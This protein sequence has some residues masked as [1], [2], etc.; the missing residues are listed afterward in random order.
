MSKPNRLKELEKIA[1][2]LGIGQNREVECV[3]CH[4]KI[5]FKDAI[6]ITNKNSVKYLCDECNKKIEKGDLNKQEQD[7]QK[8]I[9]E[10]DK[11]K[12]Q[13]IQPVPYEPKIIPWEPYKPT[14]GIG[15]DIR[16]KFNDVEYNV[17]TANTMPTKSDMLLKIQPSR[18]TGE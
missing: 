13:D 7:W 15:D 8:I 3:S 11:V 2:K 14:I 9:E 10:L 5:Q 4:K 16:W 6:I 17:Y 12:K 18:G 1:D